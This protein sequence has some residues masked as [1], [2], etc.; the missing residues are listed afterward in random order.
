MTKEE[1]LSIASSKYDELEAL[2][3]AENFY[4]YEKRFAEI[5]QELNR[6]ILEAH[7]GGSPSDYRKKK[8]FKPALEK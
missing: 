5:M 1:Y 6:L 8:D 2:K 4:E 7:L 3:T